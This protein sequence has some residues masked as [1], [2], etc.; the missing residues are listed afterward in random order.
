M[1]GDIGTRNW[2]YSSE[3]PGYFLGEDGLNIGG[4]FKVDAA[5]GKLTSNGDI[6]T[7]GQLYAHDLKVV[8]KIGFK[9]T[10]ESEFDTANDYIINWIEDVS[11]DAFISKRATGEC[12]YFGYPRTYGATLTC[13]RGPNDIFIAAGA[14]GNEETGE[15]TNTVYVRNAYLVGES[16]ANKIRILNKDGVGGA[17]ESIN[18]DEQSQVSGNITQHR[19]NYTLT[20]SGGN[21]NA[22]LVVSSDW[23]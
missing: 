13:L 10:V 16:K 21:Y 17:I 1:T 11:S 9:R 20:F 14:K 6:E 15:G 3:G 19:T 23:H 5:D 18:V 7:I 4:K 2:D 8:E 22:S 12:I